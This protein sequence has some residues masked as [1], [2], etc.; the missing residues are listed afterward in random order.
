MWLKVIYYRTNEIILPLHGSPLGPAG[1][2]SLRGDWVGLVLEDQT[3]AFTTRRELSSCV[4]L[5]LAVFDH[6]RDC[7]I[8]LNR[9][10]HHL[11]SLTLLLSG[12]SVVYM[13]FTWVECLDLLTVKSLHIRTS[14]DSELGGGMWSP[15]STVLHRATIKICSHLTH[16]NRAHRC[17]RDGNTCCGVPESHPYSHKIQSRQATIMPADWLLLSW[18]LE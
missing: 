9:K 5:Y 1:L 16:G 10:G 6:S 18:I 8:I 11:N 15:C 3:S 7:S 13:D 14:A 12:Q 2:L 17:L 4:L